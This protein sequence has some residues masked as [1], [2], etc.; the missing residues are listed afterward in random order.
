MSRPTLLN[1]ERMIEMKKRITIMI[2]LAVMLLSLGAPSAFANPPDKPGGSANPYI[3]YGVNDYFQDTLPAFSDIDYFRWHNDTGSDKSYYVYLYNVDDPSLDS[4][5]W[6]MSIGGS[7][8]Y[9]GSASVYFDQ[10]GRECWAVFVPANATLDIQVRAKNALLVHPTSLYE[11]ILMAT[12][13]IP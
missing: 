11:I 3:F 4:Q 13:P 2:L 9:P 12:P 10:V 1:I 7:V 6:S 8:S 5:I